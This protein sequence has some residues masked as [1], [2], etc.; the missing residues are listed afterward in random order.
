MKRAV[1]NPSSSLRNMLF[2]FANPFKQLL[3]FHLALSNSQ[4]HAHNVINIRRNT[5]AIDFKEGEHNVHANAFVAVNESII[6][7]QRI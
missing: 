7:D 2:I 4:S 3:V 6:G 1:R 5:Y